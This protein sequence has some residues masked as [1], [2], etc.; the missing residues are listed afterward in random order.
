MLACGAAA[1]Q[2]QHW[3][4][5]IAC[6]AAALCPPQ[7]AALLLQGPGRQPAGRLH[8]ALL[9]TGGR[10]PLSP[11]TVSACAALRCVDAGGVLQQLWLASLTPKRS[12]LPSVRSS[13][14]M[15]HPF[16]PPL[17]AGT[18]GRTQACAALCP[19]PCTRRSARQALRNATAH[20]W[21]PHVRQGLGA[22]QG[23]V[24]P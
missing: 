2:K 16:L 24:R 18:S 15:P 4:R 17:P 8:P 1:R 12:L 23:E 13:R 7:L 22:A 20:S 9:G 21:G 19:T 3:L 11:D 6:R 14:L 5:R 10:T